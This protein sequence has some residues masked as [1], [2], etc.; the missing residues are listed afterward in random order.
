MQVSRLIPC[1]FLTGF[2]PEVYSPRGKLQQHHNE[3]G[4]RGP[5]PKTDGGYHSKKTGSS[6]G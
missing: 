1:L 2:L 4:V 5:V 3:Q 6:G